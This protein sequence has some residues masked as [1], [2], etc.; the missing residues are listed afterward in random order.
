MKDLRNKMPSVILGLVAVAIGVCYCLKVFN[1]LP[2]FDLFIDGWWTIFLM[3]PGLMMLFD[4]GSNKV[5]GLVLIALGVGLFLNAQNIIS[6][7]LVKLIIP[8]LII[9]F[10]VSVIVHAFF[11]NSLHKKRVSVEVIAT[12]DGSLP[13]YDVSFGEVSPNYQGKVFDGCHM[14]VAF[15]KGTLDLTGATIEG[16][17]TI[18]VEAAFSGV[19]IILPPTC[20]LDLQ[21]NSNFGG[22]ENQFTSSSDENAPTIHVTAD[23]NFGGLVIR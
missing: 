1:I 9:V 17:K 20:K 22:V 12:S 6:V 14:E 3:V 4:R 8:I 7:D 11:G 5:V 2:D 23:V 15:G 19:E 10:G 21:S 16:D 18:E 13:R